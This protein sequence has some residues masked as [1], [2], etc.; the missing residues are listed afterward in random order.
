MSDIVKSFIG[1]LGE[2]E[3]GGSVDRIADLFAG[4]AEIGNVTLVK[5]GRG[6]DGA[7][8]FWTHYQQTVGTVKSEFRKLAD[9]NVVA[10]EW[11]TTGEAL[12][13]KAVDYEGVSIIETDGEKIT[14]FFAY[15]DPKRFGL[16]IGG[17]AQHG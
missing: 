13:G 6:V 10:L 7:R 3:S 16:E 8:E 4:D 15:F 1:A 11:R 2:V 5:S 17:K 9:G 12:D 14:R